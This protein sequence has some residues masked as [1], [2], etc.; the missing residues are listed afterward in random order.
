MLQK[1][2]PHVIEPAIGLGRLVLALLYDALCVEEVEQPSRWL[3]FDT[4]DTCM[5]EQ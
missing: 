5:C 1:L 2:F 3:V 4:R